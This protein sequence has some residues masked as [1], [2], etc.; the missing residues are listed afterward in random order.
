M[1]KILK[2]YKQEKNRLDITEKK[3]SVHLKTYNKIHPK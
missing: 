2:Y 3:R 1:A